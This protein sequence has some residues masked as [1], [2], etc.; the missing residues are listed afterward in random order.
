M[1]S[2]GHVEPPS[3]LEGHPPA[4]RP[5]SITCCRT[6][7]QYEFGTQIIESVGG[8]DGRKGVLGGW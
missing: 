8:F 2:A 4:P 3:H 7:S 5:L 6:P 1:H